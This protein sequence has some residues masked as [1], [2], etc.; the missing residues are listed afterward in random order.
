[1]AKI[2]RATQK[3]FGGNL[4]AAN[5]ISI[6]GS[7]K[8]NTLTY[9]NDPASIQ[10]LSAFTDGWGGAVINNNSPTMQDTNAIDFL[11]SRQ[12]AYLMQEGVAEWDSGTE[13]HLNSMV[14]VDNIIYYS[15]QNTNTNHLVTDIAW[16]FPYFS[17]QWLAYTPTITNYGSVAPSKIFKYR[18]VGKTIE[19]EGSI[20][21][22]ATP[23]TGTGNLTF[24]LPSG[25]TAS[26]TKMARGLHSTVLDSYQVVGSAYY[27]A[28]TGTASRS[29]FVV[30]NNASNT[31]FV[32][33]SN[34]TN[35]FPH[36]FWSVQSM[37]GYQNSVVTVKFSVE[38]A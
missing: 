3:I 37:L 28:S 29:G 11:Y 31:E 19:I 5:N 23:S 9:S 18:L 38:I 27:N 25:I 1:M 36:D 8:N 32:C 2:T 4:V 35:T 20:Y 16:W 13:Y 21:W 30:R 22:T 6:F 12:I 24:T 10:S 17:G 33:H 7:L 34:L 26:Y 14:K 15:L